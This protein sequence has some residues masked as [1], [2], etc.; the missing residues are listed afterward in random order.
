MKTSNFQKYIGG[1]VACMK[2]VMTDTKEF[3]QPNSNDT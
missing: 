3:G 1:T 2:R